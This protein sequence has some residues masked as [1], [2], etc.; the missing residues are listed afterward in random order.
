MF[1]SAPAITKYRQNKNIPLDDAYYSVEFG[2]NESQPVYQFKLWHS[3]RTPHFFLLKETS[4]LA[5]QLK[6][7]EMISMKYYCS[8]P[9]RNIERHDTRIDAIVKE[10]KGRFKGHYRIT[11]DI[12]D[13]DMAE[14]LRATGTGY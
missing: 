4:A 2:L 3:E 12:R 1:S 7:G 14:S 6:V 13:N 10:T 11:I 8:N 9:L 5:A